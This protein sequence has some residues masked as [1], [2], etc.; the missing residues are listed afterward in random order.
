MEGALK[1]DVRA[2]SPVGVSAEEIATLKVTKA[3]VKLAHLPISLP[4]ASIFKAG[5][6]KAWSG[7]PLPT[8]NSRE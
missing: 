5:D 6:R 4:L 2:S 7:P 1:A 8:H 3:F